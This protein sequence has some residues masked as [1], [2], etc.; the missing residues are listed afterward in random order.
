MLKN[1]LDFQK[2]CKGTQFEGIL[3][4]QHRFDMLNRASVA[5]DEVRPFHGIY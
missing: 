2:R 1:N 5:V 4:N 3:K